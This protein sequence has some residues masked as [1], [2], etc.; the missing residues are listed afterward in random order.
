MPAEQA[1]RASGAGVPQVGPSR[2]NPKDGFDETID[3]DTVL[4]FIQSAFF[5]FSGYLLLKIRREHGTTP[6]PTEARRDALV[7][8]S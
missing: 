5:I 2:A 8:P 3:V 6:A 4:M 7:A 1:G